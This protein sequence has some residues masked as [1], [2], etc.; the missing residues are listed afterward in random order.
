MLTAFDFENRNFR[1]TTGDVVGDENKYTV[2]VGKNGTGKSRILKAIVEHF[3]DPDTLERRRSD[4]L[5]LRTSPYLRLAYDY[6]PSN[7]IAISTSPFDRFPLPESR[8]LLIEHLG[9]GDAVYPSYEYLGLRGLFSRNLGLSFMSRTIT[10][11]I[12]SVYE[13]SQHAKQI[14]QV[15][16]YLRYDGSIEAR[17][18]LDPSISTLRRILT[19]EDPIPA[20]HDYLASR[21][22]VFRLN[23]L[24]N[25]DRTADVDD[26]IY[27][28]RRFVNALGRP[29]IDIK[30]DRF[31]AHSLNQVDLQ[32]DNDFV[33]L[34]ELGLLRLR[35]VSLR[36]LD[37]PDRIHLN[38]ASSGE[39][40]VVLGFL[41]IA[42]HIQ[43]G[44][45]ICIDEP[46]ICL[47]P[48]WQERYIQL[49]ISTFRRF[50]RCHF[51]IATHSP[52][53]VARLEEDNCF[54]LN[55]ETAH[56][57]DAKVLIKRSSDFQLATTFGAPGYKNE[58]LSRELITLITHFS[59]VGELDDEQAGL[60]RTLLKLRS[61]LDDAD[62]VASLMKMLD[63]ILVE[64]TK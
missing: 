41:G 36:K 14:C 27:A 29:R 62:P 48:E 9:S 55:I 25:R 22:E 53:I 50:K 17:F 2:I 31:G 8:R 13:N 20:L 56:I 60:A 43:D 49:L 7:V 37:T 44:S 3:V 34:L 30:I 11:L 6:Q 1:L 24:R 23:P 21:R 40:S 57:A 64:Q 61:V 33:L 46:E 12:K 16:N 10:S 52:Q 54:V 5:R 26:L 19:E 42:G 4:E 58:Y 45:L 28:L 59:K 35:G 15:L 18:Q 38:E 47:H 32:I 51:V 63:E 39:Q